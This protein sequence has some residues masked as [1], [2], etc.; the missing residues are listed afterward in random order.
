M[1]ERQI[2]AV[3][4]HYV[5]AS[6]RG[7]RVALS[8]VEARAILDEFCHAEDHQPIRAD[9]APARAGDQG[10]ADAGSRRDLAIAE[11]RDGYWI[12]GRI[13]ER[14]GARRIALFAGTPMTCLE[15]IA[16]MW[17]QFAVAGA[18]VGFAIGVK[19]F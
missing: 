1:N 3:A 5:A 17:R 15:R 10:G 11:A 7:R 4:R 18:V 6:A 12:T 19:L 16:A 14:H 13:S 8:R 2:D 9:T